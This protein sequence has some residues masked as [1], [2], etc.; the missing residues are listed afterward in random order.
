ME[1]LQTKLGYLD[2]IRYLLA[3]QTEDLAREHDNI[4]QLFKEAD[5]TLFQALAPYLF[6]T[7]SSH[8]PIVATPIDRS[9][10]GY[11]Q[12]QELVKRGG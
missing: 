12:F 11:Q 4:W 3:L 5:E 10:L 7:S 1:T 2:S 9:Y 8:D 6:I